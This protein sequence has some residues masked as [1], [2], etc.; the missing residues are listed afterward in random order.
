[1][2]HPHKDSGR[3]LKLALVITTAFF[4]LELTGGYFSGSLALISDAGHMLSD[5]LALLLSLGALTLAAQA[6]H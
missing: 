2:V 6:P 4:I 1:M 3:S 5:V